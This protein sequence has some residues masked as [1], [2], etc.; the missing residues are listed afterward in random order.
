MTDKATGGVLGKARA[1]WGPSGEST[2]RDVGSD[3]NSVEFLGV[4]NPLTSVTSSAGQEVGAVPDAA[5]AGMLSQI[6]VTPSQVG[7]KRASPDDLVDPKRQRAD[8]MSVA[9]SSQSLDAEIG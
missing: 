2:R 1:T 6:C 9:N 3:S 8:G 5:G 7:T 4:L